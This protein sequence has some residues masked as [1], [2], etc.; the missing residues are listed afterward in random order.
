MNTG[1]VIDDLDSLIALLKAS[2]GDVTTL[3]LM[4]S[5][6]ERLGRAEVYSFREKLG[7]LRWAIFSSRLAERRTS[8]HKPKRSDSST[9]PLA[10][11]PLD[12]FSS[13]KAVGASALD[14]LVKVEV[15]KSVLRT[16]VP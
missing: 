16:Y 8:S 15:V 9:V 1:E 14:F 7:E 5:V 12:V 2:D 6:R 11:K 3:A 13:D 4:E 10:S